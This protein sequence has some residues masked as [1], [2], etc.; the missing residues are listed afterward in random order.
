M[1]VNNK[2]IAKN[3]LLLYLRMMI[4]VIVSLYT[5]R[6]VLQ[7]LGIEDFGI[8]NVVGGVVSLISF[9][10][11]SLS[12]ATQRYL[13]YEMGLNNT[14][15]MKKIFSASSLCYF[16]IAIVAVILA[17]TIGIWFIKNKLVIPAYR[18]D[19]ALWV[20]H[21]SVIS[22]VI[23]LL[24]VTYNAVIV[25]YEE[26]SIYAYVSI[27]NVSLKLLL[28]FLLSYINAD[29]L[30]LYAFLMMLVT[31][32]QAVAYFI[33]CKKKFAIC[34][35]EFKFDRE[36]IKG[37]FSF[38]G[39]MLSGTITSLLNIQGVNMLI[40]M[41]FGPVYNAARAVATQINGTI[42]NFSANFLTAVRPQVVKSY[43]EQNFDEMYQLVYNSS[44]LS[45]FLLYLLTLP[46][47][48][49]IDWI[50][51]LWLVDVPDQ[52]QLFTQLVLLDLLIVSAY[53]PIGYVSQAANKIKEYQLM[54]SVCFLTTPLLTWI[55]YKL[56]YNAYTT[57]VIAI[58]V[59]IIGYAL[60]LIILKKTVDFPVLEYLKSV[61]Y[62]LLKVVVAGVIFIYVPLNYYSIM[63]ILQLFVSIIATICIIWIF[64]MNKREHVFIIDKLRNFSSKIKA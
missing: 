54:I 21:F 12:T 22:F 51:H 11:G 34:K 32:T 37:L 26:F 44:R 20:F 56:G 33:I 25:A 46:M 8:Y 49:N 59:D 4:I 3:T 18:I 53:G 9:L 43:A 2:R 48:L 30:C 27:A 5:S 62:P 57:F 10:Y 16:V 45:F 41:Y 55:A 60:R 64:G 19:V 36:L 29:K 50:L 52:T 31:L 42:N 23:E 58:A 14:E 24:M 39:W 61:V 1:A 47:I 6:V 63:P 38:S 15:N 17:E 35:L 28:V 40:N 13:N 7:I